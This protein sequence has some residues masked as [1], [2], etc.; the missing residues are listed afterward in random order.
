[1]PIVAQ[2]TPH[3][4]RVSDIGSV[5]IRGQSVS[6]D[7]DGEAGI[8]E[9]E[10]LI[11]YCQYAVECLKADAMVRAVVRGMVADDARFDAAY[12]ARLAE[13]EVAA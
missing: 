4:Y 8:E 12:R 6:I 2:S 3:V 1:M 9:L 7:L 11:A 10:A 13:R 5:Q